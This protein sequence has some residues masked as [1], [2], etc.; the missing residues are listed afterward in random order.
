MTLLA[1]FILIWGALV[2]VSYFIG[3]AIEAMWGSGGEPAGFSDS[4]FRIDLCG[5]AGCRALSDPRGASQSD[6][7]NRP[8][9]DRWRAALAQAC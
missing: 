7:R 8:V 5:L 9:F 2:A 1:V 4:V 6:D 3:L